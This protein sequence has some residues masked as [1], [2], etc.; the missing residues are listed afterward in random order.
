[1]PIQRV[2]IKGALNCVRIGVLR[3]MVEAS[4]R[5]HAGNANQH[6]RM[7]L[8]E[9]IIIEVVMR[10]AVHPSPSPGPNLPAT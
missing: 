2:K 1:M 4:E 9:K 10:S 6:L 8:P 3:S 5:K 7:D